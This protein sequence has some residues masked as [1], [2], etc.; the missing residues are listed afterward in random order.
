MRH[1]LVAFLLVPL[2]ISVPGLAHA[3]PDVGSFD[4]SPVGVPLRTGKV[5][6]QVTITVKG[7]PVT[8]TVAI[9]QGAIKP[10]VMPARKPGEKFNAWVDRVATARGEAAQAKATVIADAINKTFSAEFKQLGETVKTGIT[11]KPDRFY[12]L[13]QTVRR[14]V[15]FGALVI[16]SVSKEQ[17]NPIKITEVRLGEGSNGGR[18]I[19]AAGPSPGSRGSLERAIPG[20]Q[21]VA[22]GLDPLGN[23]SEVEFGLDGTY[24]ADFMPIKGMTD[25]TV[26]Q[27]L[28]FLLKKNGVPA[29]YDSSDVTLFLDNPIPDGVQLDWGNTDAGLSFATSIEPIPGP[30][31]WAILLSGIGLAGV[32]CR[33]RA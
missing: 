7:K 5:T 1:I 9:P 20:F 31:A 2:S 25:A 33:R 10:F 28:A 17:G 24:V 29:T 22:T 8:K 30:P 4:F 3:A 21:T 13:G 14:M 6:I 27:G 11:V 12:V 16:P 18:F 15:T 23:P 26:L 19:P 32:V